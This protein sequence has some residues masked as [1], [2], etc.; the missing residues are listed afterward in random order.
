M[1]TES[2]GDREVQPLSDTE[3]AMIQDTWATVYKDSEDVGVSILLRFFVNFPSA[4]QLFA[5]FKSM[6]DP[7]EMRHSAHL[8]RHAGQV[9]GAIDSMLAILHDP[10]RM[11]STLESVARRHALRHNVEYFEILSDVTLEVLLESYP[12]CFTKEVQSA[13]KKLMD[14]IQWH[15]ARTYAL[16]SQPSNAT[17]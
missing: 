15:V 7:G 8:R 17:V 10:E 1:A 2:K 5:Q 14:L 12:Q 13:W 11:S 6:E 16:L 4:R 9:M 3:K